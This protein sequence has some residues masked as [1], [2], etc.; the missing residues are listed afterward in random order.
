MLSVSVSVVKILRNY[1]QQQQEQHKRT[2]CPYN[3]S[4]TISQTGAGADAGV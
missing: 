2:H 3:Y 1:Q 4:R